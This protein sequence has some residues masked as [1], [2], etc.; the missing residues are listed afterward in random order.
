MES[1]EQRGRRQFEAEIARVRQLEAEV[2]QIPRITPPAARLLVIVL[3]G[4]LIAF[5]AG[6]VLA[7]VGSVVR[8]SAVA[9]IGM[10]GVV[11]GLVVAIVVMYPLQRLRTGRL[12]FVARTLG[13]EYSARDPFGMTAG[14]VP[15]TVL[16]RNTGAGP[17]T[18][19][20][21][22][23][24]SY[25]GRE[26]RLFDYIPRGTPDLAALTCGVAEAPFGGSPM[27]LRRPATSDDSD[28]RVLTE[29]GEFN[30]EFSVLSGDP[31]WAITFLDARLMV[32]LLD[33][34]PRDVSFEVRP[35]AVL[36]WRPGPGMGN[37]HVEALVA[38]TSF[39]DRIPRV[40]ASLYPP[41]EELAG[42]L[43]GDNRPSPRAGG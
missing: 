37:E 36:C 23:W 21:V 22:M 33:H 19:S 38:L 20:N 30:R 15:F 39:M 34:S 3:F 13:L 2:P 32:W 4:V 40:V 8:N 24:G 42:S 16:A 28:L 6:I 35:G 26:V 17:P 18:F 1:P 27:S 7:I 29:W 25:R 9:G 41:A 12:P 14:S 10:T 31:K 5:V 11:V 43:L